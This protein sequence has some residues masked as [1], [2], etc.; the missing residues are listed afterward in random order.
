VVELGKLKLIKKDAELP[1]GV[2]LK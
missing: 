2:S 1:P